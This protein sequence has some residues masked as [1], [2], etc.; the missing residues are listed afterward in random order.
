MIRA[1]ALALVLVR[2]FSGL[3]P[4][5]GRE[6]PA[7][8]RP[9][10]YALVKTIGVS[11]VSGWTDA[12]FDVLVD[13]EFWFEAT[14]T[15]CLQTGNPEAYCDPEGIKV[16]TMQQPLPE[17]NLGCLVGKV[18][19][20]V[21]TVEDPETK[22]KTVREFGVVFYI[23]KAGRVRMPADGRLLLGPNENVTGDNDGMFSV[24]I[25]RRD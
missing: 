2:F 3:P 7:S 24:L 12:G 16:R 17:S 6:N 9:A 13:Q 10:G 11:G 19:Q 15:I 18:L 1:F 23:G 5:P 25:Y 14:G 4:G 22:E 8:G 21:A 20:D